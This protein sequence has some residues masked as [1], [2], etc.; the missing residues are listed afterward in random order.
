MYI[1]E[2][3]IKDNSTV[4]KF[5]YHLVPEILFKKF[6]DSEGN[7]NCRNKKEWGKNSSFIHTSPTKKQLK[8]KV[9]NIN[10]INYPREEKFLLLKINTQ[11][12]KAKFTYTIINGSIYHHIWSKLPKNSFK[13]LKV[14]RGRNGKFLI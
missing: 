12:I 14:K 4:P 2:I 11:N 13:V 5:L 10:W 6:A 1:K 3:E 8:E 7:Y 9:A